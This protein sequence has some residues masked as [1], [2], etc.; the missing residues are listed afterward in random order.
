VRDGDGYAHEQI[1]GVVHQQCVARRAEIPVALGT[2]PEHP[3]GFIEA[4]N[5]PARRVFVLVLG[6]IAEN[7]RMTAPIHE[8]S[9]DTDSVG[10]IGPE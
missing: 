3:T 9:G 2:S 10:T 6:M 4:A 7:I 8:I 5:R 1:V